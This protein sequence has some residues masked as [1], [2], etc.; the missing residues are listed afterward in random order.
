MKRLKLATAVFTIGLAISSSQ[1]GFHIMQIEQII[2]GINGDVTAQAIQLRLR[3]GGQNFVSGT[4]LIA[5]D[6]AGN[7]AIT[8]IT[9]P[10]SVTNGTG[11]DNI[12][13]TTSA[14]NTVMSSVPGYVA[15]FTLTN[16]IPASYLNGGKLT[17]Q[18]GATIYWSVAFGAYAGTNTGDATNDADGNFGTPTVALPSSGRQGVRFT[19]AF[20]AASTTN[21]ADYALTADPAT[22]RNNARTSFVVAPEPT[23]AALLAVG[24][25]GLGGIVFARRRR[26]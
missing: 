6:A 26:A 24:A 13:L 9:I 16:P 20:G 4:T 14:F 8:L 12:L 10:A 18:A 11:G 3:Q 7:N 19:G 22:V 21:A 25:F 1:A 23:S 2:G 15:D 17:F 5:R